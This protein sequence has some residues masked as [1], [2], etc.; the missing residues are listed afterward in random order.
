MER[1]AW[2]AEVKEGCL[3]EYI[4]RHNNIWLEMKEV[5]KQAG[6]CNYSI[7]VDGNALFGYYE[8]SKGSEYSTQVQ[9][10]SRIVKRWNEYMAD[11][12]IWKDAKEQPRMTEVFRLD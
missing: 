11:I 2:R 4:K 3:E 5:L 8:C 10:E 1:Y 6:I 9:Q 7:F 12:L